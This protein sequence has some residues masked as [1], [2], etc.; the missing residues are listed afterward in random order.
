[1]LLAGLKHWLLLRQPT[2]KTNWKYLT[3]LEEL[4]ALPERIADAV[5]GKKDI[6]AIADV[7]EKIVHGTL[8]T[9]V[10]R[11][12]DRNEFPHED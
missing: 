5:T 3:T 9:L 11:L 2:P 1:M 10:R 6:A 7:S 12:K 8:N 4:H